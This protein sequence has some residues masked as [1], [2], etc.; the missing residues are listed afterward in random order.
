MAPAVVIDISAQAARNP[1]Y[2]LSKEDV[3]AWEKKNGKL[4]TGAII[5]LRTGW[6]S[7][8]PDAMTYLGDDTPGDA[9]KLHFPSYGA[10]AVRYLIGPGKA[11]GLSV[12][13]ASIDFGASKDFIVHR[14][15]LRL[16]FVVGAAVSG[17]SG[18]SC[19]G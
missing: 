9:S 3:L 10:E 5:R 14:H 4:P 19:F 17:F 12:D 2:R 16:A 18:H 11:G 13:V 1:D 8:W 6:S 15:R 7:R